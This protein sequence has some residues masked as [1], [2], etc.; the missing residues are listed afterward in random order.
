MYNTPLYELFSVP[1]IV[2]N[3][4]KCQDIDFTKQLEAGIRYLD[5]RV[6]TKDG[7]GN[8][9]YLLHTMFSHPVQYMAEAVE[10]YLQKHKTEIV[11]LDFNH[12]HNISTEQHNQCIQMLQDI[13]GDN[14]C[15]F[16]EDI[17]DIS[18]NYLWENKFQVVA[19]YHNNQAEKN[20]YFWPGESIPSPWP[21]TTSHKNMLRFLDR[22]YK[23]G[24]DMKKF[25]VT[26]GVLTP[27]RLMV[28]THLCSTVK[29]QC[30][31]K[32]GGPFVS[33]LQDKMAGNNGI[34]VCI[35]NFVHEYNYIPTVL[36]L[37]QKL[38][39]NETSLDN[40]NATAQVRD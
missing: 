13:F 34:N 5:L 6:S 1:T 4:A 23:K 21:N 10:K 31:D 18:L 16:S 30:S 11:L 20:P 9:L 14:M 28:A 2:Y 33:W 29:A 38:V 36:S 27:S 25:H 15:K 24:R 3:W 7:C 19:F 8:D 35:I 37:N 22:N 17:E 40:M 39:D 32:C 26:Q 12:F